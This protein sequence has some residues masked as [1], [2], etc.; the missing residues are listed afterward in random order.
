MSMSLQS[1]DRMANRLIELNH[2]YEWPLWQL[3]QSLVDHYFR[4]Y[5]ESFCFYGQS[6]WTNMEER[7]RSHFHLEKNNKHFPDSGKT[8]NEGFQSRAEM[9]IDPSTLN[10]KQVARSLAWLI[11]GQ[12]FGFENWHWQNSISFSMEWFE[13]NNN[14]IGRLV[15]QLGHRNTIEKPNK[16]TECFC[17]RR[18]RRRRWVTKTFVHNIKT[19]DSLVDFLAPL[20]YL[21]AFA[22]LPISS[23]LISSCQLAYLASIFHCSS[24]SRTVIVN[25]I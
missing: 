22:S 20:F 25:S 12:E 7:K 17:C 3:S 14:N 2:R 19:S 13:D 1:I 23:H 15:W 16:T 21:S 10:S 8:H 4:C 24:L 9:M 6:Q 11:A 18:R 5:H